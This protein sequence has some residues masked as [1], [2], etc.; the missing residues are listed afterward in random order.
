MNTDENQEVN[1]KMFVTEYTEKNLR[2]TAAWTKFYAIFSFI[3]AGIVFLAGIFL[4]FFAS[5]IMSTLPISHSFLGMK[6]IGFGYIVASIITLIPAILLYQFSK[7]TKKSLIDNNVA[8]LE[9]G[10]AK[11]KGY[12]IFM[13]VISIISIISAFVAITITTIDIISLL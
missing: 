7:Y 4:L 9:V 8:T 2:I 6:T 5:K 11:M 1:R 13:G 3:A 10:I 12:W